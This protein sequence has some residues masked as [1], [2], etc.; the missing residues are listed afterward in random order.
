VSNVTKRF[1]SQAK[2]RSSWS[3]AARNFP[4]DSAARRAYLSQ[5]VHAQVEAMFFS[6]ARA[7][8][9]AE[10]ARE[11]YAADERHAHA[12]S[13]LVSTALSPPMNNLTALPEWRALESH[14]ATVKQH[15]CV[16]YSL[17]IPERFA[18][19]S[20]CDL[21]LL[22]DYSRNATAET[23]KKLFALAEAARFAGR[24][25]RRCLRATA[26]TTPKI[27]RC[28]MWRCAIDEATHTR[29]AGAHFRHH[30]FA[31]HYSGFTG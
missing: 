15:S 10:A 17:R 24:T 11:D 19:F 30:V 7:D 12:Y 21:D 13:F 16:I 1:A 6:R 20:C 29:Q 4:A 22:F 9:V 23:L 26:S 5:R 8:G 18:Q 3:S 25:L 28:C 31:I 14:A 2:L 27:D